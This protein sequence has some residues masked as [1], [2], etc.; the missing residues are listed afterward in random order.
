MAVFPVMNRLSSALVAS[1][2]LCSLVACATGPHRTDAEKQA[3]K[4]TS[5]RVQSALDADSHLYAKHI[6][7]RTYSGVVHL[8]GYV[9]EPPDLVEA[10]RVAENV[11]GVSSVVNDLELQR[12]GTDNSGVAR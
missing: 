5:D 9:W 4:E 8:S 12:N 7:V 1:A 3:D 2:I 6:T 10:Q 11:S